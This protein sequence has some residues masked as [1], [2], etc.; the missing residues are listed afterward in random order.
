MQ[1][2]K[3]I[4]ARFHAP[5]PEPEAHPKKCRRETKRR[6]KELA[7][8]T[9]SMKVRIEARWLGARC[10]RCRSCDLARAASI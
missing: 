7:R 5:M 9:P 8:Q 4:E 10:A 1:P 6:L 3:F 2:A